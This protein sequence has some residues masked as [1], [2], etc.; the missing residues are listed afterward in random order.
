MNEILNEIEKVC[1][2][3]S[4][5]YSIGVWSGACSHGRTDYMTDDHETVEEAVAELYQLVK[6]IVGNVSE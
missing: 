4:I 1:D 5:D 3:V 6:H 2:L